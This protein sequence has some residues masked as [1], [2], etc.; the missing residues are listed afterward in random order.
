MNVSR[1]ALPRRLSI[2]GE[3]NG[4]AG[5][6]LSKSLL[7]TVTTGLSIALVTGIV[8]WT[9]GNVITNNSRLERLQ[10]VQEQVLKHND[11][12]DQQ[13]IDAVKDRNERLHQVDERIR[14]LEVQ[15]YRRNDKQ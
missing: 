8:G 2:M 6:N 3:N 14:Q 5:L 11:W 13:L 15:S 9:F 10:T 4:N 1:P 12:Q 7:V